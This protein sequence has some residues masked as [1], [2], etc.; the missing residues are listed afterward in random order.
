M[1]VLW[2]AVDKFG[3]VVFFFVLFLK[4]DLYKGCCTCYLLLD[5]VV[6]K[7]IEALILKYYIHTYIFLLHFLREIT[8]DLE[9][10]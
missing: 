8:P 5:C 2:P 4:I 7:Q 9:K 3:V 1:K 6:L 10:T